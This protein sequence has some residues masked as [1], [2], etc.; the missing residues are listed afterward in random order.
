MQVIASWTGGQAD[1]LRHALRMTNES[2]ADHLGVSVRAVAYW[3]NRPGMVPQLKMQEVL[4]AALEQA[5]DRV[6]AQFSLLVG[7]TDD[8]PADQPYTGSPFSVSLDGM[9]STEWNA[10]DARQLSLSFDA[11]LERSAVERLSHMWLIC[12]PPQVIELNAGR[13]IN[14]ALVSAVE[15][16][17]VQLRRADDFITG[18]AS[19]DLMRAELAATTLLLSEGTLTEE[20]A[21]R[22]LAA[23]GE[24]AQ[25]GASVAG[26]GGLLDEAARYVR[27]GV[28]AARAAGDAPLAA[29]I[30]STFSYQLA[31]TGNPHEALVLARTAYQGARHDATPVTRA[32]LL[33]RIAWAAARA[34]DLRDCERTLGMVEESFS[35]GPGD[36]DPDWL[37][38]LNREEVDVMAGR[39]YTE[40]RQ[41]ARAESLLTSAMARYGP[42]FVRENS[43]YLSWL[44]EAYVQLGEIEHAAGI[45]TQMAALAAHTNS[46]RT[47]AR[48][49]YIAGQLG[50]YR[51]TASVAGFFDAYQAAAAPEVPAPRRAE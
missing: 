32:L 47:D 19:R 26:D 12:D 2:F 17:V 15:H 7:E 24:L 29:N 41:P 40:L 5:P 13:R 21:R 30:I 9:A 50:P 45:A 27:G 36:Q 35:A 44:A 33:E 31:N 43:L 20:Q 8:A 34:G 39:C 11:A 25:L 10:D 14:D 49:H 22:V 4:D 51:E 48:L 37:Y 42:E 28:L 1:A 23:I 6:K 18:T 16:R 38:W 3:R 46:A